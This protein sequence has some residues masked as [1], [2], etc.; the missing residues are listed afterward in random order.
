[1]MTIRKFILIMTLPFVLHRSAESAFRYGFSEGEGIFPYSAPACDPR[2]VDPSSVPAYAPLTGGLFLKTSYTRPYMIEGLHSCGVSG[3]YASSRIGGGFMW[4]RF[5]IDQYMEDRIA[6]FSGLRITDQLLIGGRIHADRF[7]VSVGDYSSRNTVYDADAMILL[8]PLPSVSIA[9]RQDNIHA[10]TNRRR[11]DILYPDSSFGV[12]I[13]P[14]P[15]IS[16]GWNYLHN[17]DSGINSLHVRATILPSF[18]VSSGYARETST[19]AVCANLLVKNITVTYGFN[20]HAYLG[21][22]HRV[23]IV[24]SSAPVPFE[25]IVMYRKKIT[26]EIT[27]DITSCSPDDIMRLSSITEDH[28][29]RIVKYRDKIAPVT[30]RALY[31][32]GLSK[33]EISEILTHCTGIVVEKNTDKEEQPKWQSFRKNHD[34]HYKKKAQTKSLFIRLVDAGIPPATAIKI[35]DTVGDKTGKD[36]ISRIDALLEIP[37]E[38]RKKAKAICGN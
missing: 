16:C 24:L 3:G 31:Q 20:Y 10:L 1:M 2:F 27:I 23:G 32:L 14:E 35:A 37:S 34:T 26:E 30:E 9:Y 7:A 29:E 28:A 11:R 19:Y 12:V 22:T 25:P 8:K 33:T 4:N 36:A 5:G 38:E 6:V 21:M 13:S 18:S 15:G 17:H